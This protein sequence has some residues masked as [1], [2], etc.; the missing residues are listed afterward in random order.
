M[1]VKEEGIMN[2]LFLGCAVGLALAA[3]SGSAS[4]GAPQ[5]GLAIGKDPLLLHLT[6]CGNN[7]PGNDAERA[8]IY[9]NNGTLLPEEEWGCTK[10]VARPNDPENNDF[11]QNRVE[12]D[13]G[14][15]VDLED[16]NSP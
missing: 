13:P 12:A 7:G 14:A 1:N 10:F 16:G 9:R 3:V 8:R 15:T 4:A 5:G 11:N 2:K 6:K